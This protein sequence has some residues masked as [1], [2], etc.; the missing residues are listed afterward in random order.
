MDADVRSQSQDERREPLGAQ[1]VG[2]QGKEAEEMWGDLEEVEEVA[3]GEEGHWE[4]REEGEGEGEGEARAQGKDP[5]ETRGARG[6]QRR[7]SA[8]GSR[9]MHTGGSYTS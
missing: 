2:P 3:W 4:E 6:Q 8:L 7:R 5:D 1:T 9:F